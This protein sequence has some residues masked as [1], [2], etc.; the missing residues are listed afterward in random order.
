VLIIIIIII[1]TIIIIIIIII[2]ITAFCEHGDELSDSINFL[3]F[4]DLV[5][6]C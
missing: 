6:Y 3:N 2:I 5:T 1:I 4:F